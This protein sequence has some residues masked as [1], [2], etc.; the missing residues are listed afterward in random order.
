MTAAISCTGITKGFPGV[1]AL[2]DVSITV[3][4]GT[5]HAL[6]GENGA[7]KSTLIRVL[8]GAE[9]PDA[10]TVHIGGTQLRQH[11]PAAARRLGVRV[12]PQERHIAADL[13]VGHNVLLDAVPRTVLGTVS[14]RQV[15][16]RAQEHLDALG[17]DLDAHARAG[18]LTAAQ[19]QLVELAR[20]TARPAAVVVLDEPTASLAGDEVAV[21]FRVVRQLRDRG[22][23]L[24][25]I[26]HHL[27]EVFELADRATV[28]RNGRLV[29]ETEVADTDHDSLLRH[30][31]DRDVAHTRL[32]RRVLPTDAP[33]VLAATSVTLP[34]STRPVDVDVR[35]GEV[36][37]L[38]GPSGAGASDLAEV[39]AGVRVASQGRVLLDGAPL[40]ARPAAARAGIGFVPSDRKRNAL[41][42]ERAITENLLVGPAAKDVWHRPFA[43]RRTAWEALRAGRVKADDP[44][45]PVRTLSGGNQQRVVFARWLLADCRVL[46]LDQPTAG[47]D[48]GAK[49][50]I[51][52]QLLELAADGVAV[53]VVSSDYEEIC[54]LADRVL[55]L[56]GGDVVADVAGDRATPDGLFALESM[57]LET[58]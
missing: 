28:L 42:L 19:Q 25:Y 45:R 50:D 24:L 5:V 55:V 38:S 40:G 31:F 26:S 43:S 41:L 6:L 9:R 33:V 4:P 53:V 36:I 10:G 37:A 32:P 20:T 11:T 21:L 17:L 18:D 54:A 48:V 16:R 47:V 15:Q 52:A 7:G 46:V 58:R 57:P 49:F 12:L 1:L 29:H 13:S 2:D 34:G 27:H 22:S 23:A 39:L 30:V 51:Y 44:G 56:R 35:A 14:A 3:R 8:T